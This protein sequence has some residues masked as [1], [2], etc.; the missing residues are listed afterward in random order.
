MKIIDIN[1]LHYNV[2]VFDCLLMTLL[3][4]IENKKIR[5]FMFPD[6][7]DINSDTDI[8]QLKGWNIMYFL[9]LNIGIYI[10]VKEEKNDF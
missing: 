6:G 3:V 2:G 9:H 10:A 8:I 7:N 5:W 4:G 1:K